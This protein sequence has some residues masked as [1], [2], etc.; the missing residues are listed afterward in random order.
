MLS[1]EGVIVGV[2]KPGSVLVSPSILNV[3]EEGRVPETENDPPLST[4][5]QRIAAG[6]RRD[7][8]IERHEVIDIAVIRREGNQRFAVE[9]L[10]DR[11]GLLLDQSRTREH[12]DFGR[13]SC[14]LQRDVGVDATADVDLNRLDEQTSQIR[15]AP[16]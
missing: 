15:S 6:R 8:G 5:R 1:S 9:H 4:E 3:I 12:G 16:R 2:P 13:Q 11:R 7:V 10:A 14:R